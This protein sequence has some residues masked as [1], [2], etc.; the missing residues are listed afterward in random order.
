MIVWF[1]GI[2]GVGKTTLAKET[3]KILKK[4]IKNILHID[5]DKFR[6]MMGNDLGF[7]LKDRNKN[8]QRLI[9]FVKFFINQYIFAF[10]YKFLLLDN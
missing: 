6:K 1:T 4:K 9:N 5:G 10:E 8:A 3:F 2:S 7:S